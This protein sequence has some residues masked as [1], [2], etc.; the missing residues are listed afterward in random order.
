MSLRGLD[1]SISHT[2][3]RVDI[4]VVTKGVNMA[5]ILNWNFL[6]KFPASCF[7]PG[8]GI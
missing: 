8:F 2:V 5:L 7:V 1:H 4:Y 6:P 3:S